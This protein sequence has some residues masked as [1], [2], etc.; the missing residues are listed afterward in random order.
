LFIDPCFG[1]DPHKALQNDIDVDNQ[2]I[3]SE[4]VG[5]HFATIFEIMIVILSITS[6]EMEWDLSL[7]FLHV[8]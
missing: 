3:E 4:L 1:C 8:F 6:V 7:R 2:D 5:N